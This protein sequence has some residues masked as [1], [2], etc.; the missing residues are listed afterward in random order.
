MIQIEAQRQFY[1]GAAGVRLWYARE[2]LPGAAPSP[3]FLFPEPEE[4]AQHPVSGQ[5][6]GPDAGRVGSARSFP[7]ADKKSGQRIASLQALMESKAEPESLGAT[8]TDPLVATETVES[9]S[10]GDAL[11]VDAQAH[12]LREVNLSL[13][14]FAGV[15]YVLVADISKAASLR[16]QETLA[17]NILKSLG[18]DQTSAPQW[19]DWPVFRN[20]LV[21]GN[22]LTDLRAVMQSVLTETAGRKV[23]V[24]G[25]LGDLGGRS[26]ET[27]WLVDVLG[28]N[29][30]VEYEHSLAALASNPDL[31]RSLWQQLKP[32][33]RS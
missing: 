21:P 6:T 16:L 2:P 4:P 8:E 18:D 5:K 11:S 26:R 7:A 20:R 32:L 23:I 27:G 22:S 14:V 15:N 28:R 3:E 24:L 19:V 31:K 29:P 1:L 12:A 33:G 9:V 25:T 10:K 17:T 13:G 30:D